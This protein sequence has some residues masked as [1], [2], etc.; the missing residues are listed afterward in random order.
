MSDPFG[1]FVVQGFD[2]FKQR[3]QARPLVPD[4]PSAIKNS[5]PRS[6]C[7]RWMGNGNSSITFSRNSSQL[8]ALR[9]LY[10]AKHAN[11]RAVVN[12]GVLIESRRDLA[13]VHLNPLAGNFLCV[14]F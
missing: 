1:G 10:T 8:A 12:R 5:R 14:P 13:R 9:R 7:I 4:L 3:S 11:P 2:F 6:V